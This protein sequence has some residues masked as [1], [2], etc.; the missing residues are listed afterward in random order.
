MVGCCI[1]LDYV[2]CEKIKEIFIMFPNITP[3]LHLD[4]QVRNDGFI[5]ICEILA[6]PE[7]HPIKLH[8]HY[9]SQH[10]RIFVIEITYG[11]TCISTIGFRFPGV[12]FICI[13]RKWYK[14]CYKIFILSSFYF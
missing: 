5:N 4:F 11:I 8:S 14:E 7:Y 1:N 12:I 13:V 10:V 6:R 3:L 2:I 9:T